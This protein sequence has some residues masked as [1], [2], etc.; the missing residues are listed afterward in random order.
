MKLREMLES[1]YR[2][3]ERCFGG[4]GRNGGDRLL[5]HMDLKPHASGDYSIAVVQANSSLEDQSQVFTSPSATYVGVYDGHGGPEASRFITNHLFPFLHKFTSEQGGLSAEVIRKAFD[6]TEE[7]FLH[8]VKRSWLARPQIASVGSCCLVGAISNDVLYV[9][10]LGDSR[11]VLG[12]RVSDGRT[13]Y[14][15]P[16]VA[17]RLSTDH[18][19][20]VEEVRKEVEALHPDDS[21]IVVYTRGVWRIK[22][23]IQ[24]SRSI[25]DIYLKK[26]EF[27][28]DPLF[29][30]FG[31][32]VPLRRA[33]MSAEPSI[34]IRKL[35]P[36]DLFLIFASDGL[37][38]QLSD[39]AAVELVLKNPR[40]GIAKRLVRAA[41]QEAARKRELRYDDIKRI[42]KGVRRHFHDDITVIVIYLDHQQGTP[43]VRSRDHC[44]VDCTS[45]PV[46][47]FSFNAD[48]VDNT[49]HTFP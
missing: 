44:M 3:L 39:E 48:E 40:V 27:N 33:V 17:E 18:N 47:I 28:R 2:R 35:R 1:C 37:W 31:L 24:V 22:G 41:I 20:G 12:R 26:P 30:Q 34:L 38:E 23:I 6:A 11:V 45:A 16:V 7:E 42:E 29:Q 21:H 19:V 14:S 32:P 13:S 25:G 10:N 5:W 49:P 15:T 43:N 9:A 8:L 36:Q 46:D 4:G